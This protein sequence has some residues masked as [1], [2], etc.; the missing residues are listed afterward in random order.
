MSLGTASGWV[1]LV[2]ALLLASPLSSPARTLVF[3][4]SDPSEGARWE[5]EMHDSTIGSLG[6]SNGAFLIASGPAAP[7]T[8]TREVDFDASEFNR[9]VIDLYVEASQTLGGFVGTAVF[10][11][12]EDGFP[13][14]E[15][16]LIAT[17]PVGAFTQTSIRLDQSVFWEGRIRKLRIDPVW[18]VGRAA[19]TRISLDTEPPPA[20]APHYDFALSESALG[21]MTGEFDEAAGSF[22]PRQAARDSNGIAFFTQGPNQVLQNMDARL[23]ADLIRRAELTLRT[24]QP[25]DTIARFFWTTPGDMGAG[26]ERS[27]MAQVRPTTDW[28]TLRFELG[29]H[30]AWTGEIGLVLINPTMRPGGT[31]IRSLRFEP[32]EGLG[33]RGDAGALVQWR[34]HQEVGHELASGN[35]KP[36]LVLVT[37]DGNPFSQEMEQELAG[38]RAFLDRVQQFHAV[39]LQFGDPATARVFPDIFRVPVLATMS[40]DFNAREWRTNRKLMGRE[41]ATEAIALIDESLGQ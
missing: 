32:V 22:I 8:M 36:L 26:M 21:W 4:F 38:N 31:Q 37:R 29:S 15:S 16:R 13:I 19:V 5:T 24:D 28:Q 40:Y 14:A 30:H 34:T 41:V 33:Q 12:N 2:L 25:V 10:L 11:H 35:Y 20:P 7:A 39:R 18:G 27:L 17:T 3:D 9:L 6:P 23:N 1:G